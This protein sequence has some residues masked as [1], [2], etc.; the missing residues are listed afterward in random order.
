[1]SEFA[2]VAEQQSADFDRIVAPLTDRLRRAFVARF[3]VEVGY[4]V[5]AETMA[6]AW[7]HRD[8]LGALTNPAGY[9][10]R[11]GQS[12]ARRH[13][14]WSRGTGLFPMD[15]NASW[16]DV[17]ELDWDVLQALRKLKPKE[18]VA[19]LLVHGYGFSYREVAELFD[20]TEANITNHIHRGLTKLRRILKDES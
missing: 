6:W 5:H 20:L 17:P 15:A 11:V 8:Q 9:L 1:V 2:E 3:G 14:R 16:A 12:A 13:Q 7:Q 18:R 19:V 4:D 10:F